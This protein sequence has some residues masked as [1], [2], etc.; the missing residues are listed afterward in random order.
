MKIAKKHS[1]KHLQ[2]HKGIALVVVLFSLLLLSLLIVGLLLRAG[3]ENRSSSQY[4]AN[5]SVR[6]LS[7]M[8]VN[9]VQAQIN[10]ATS[11]SPSMTWASQPGAIR[12]FS[13][14]GSLSLI[15]KLYSS[16]ALT[17]STATTL[18][19][20]IPS[21]TWTSQPA[22]WTD[23]N[24]P[25]TTTQ[26]DG[27]TRTLF[28]V[29]DP[30]NPSDLSSPVNIEGFTLAVPPG[31]ATTTQP[32]PMPVRWLYVLQDGRMVSPAVGENN[33][34]MTINGA[35]P[36]N[37][38]V[39]RIAFWTD[40]ETCKININ[41]A[42]DGTFWDT[43]HFNASDERNRSI[44]Q[45]AQGEF[46]AYPGHPAT[47]TLQK[48]F[49]GL[50]NPGLTTPQLF[51]ISPRYTF[52]GSQSGNK[53]ATSPI[54]KKTER[55]YS[56]VGELLF[57]P[58]RTPNG[59]LTSQQLE[60]ARFFLTAHSSAPEVT[61]FGTPRVAI[62]PIH[63]TNDA[64]HRSAIDKLIAFCSTI[65]GHPF[66]F[67][68]NNP[69]SRTDD[70]SL[71]RNPTL[72]NYLDHFTSTA[73]PGFENSFSSK[74]G[75]PGS[76]QIL[77]EIFDYIRI[78]NLNDPTVTSPYLSDL[79]NF[80]TNGGGIG[81]VTPSYH[82]DW[83]TRGLGRFP[84]LSEVSML[85][86]GMGKGASGTTAA[87]PVDPRQPLPP[88]NQL[89]PKSYL[90][91][92]GK[93]TP[94]TDTTAVQGFLLLNFF[95]PAH[96]FSM[97]RPGF[98][99]IVNGLNYFTL[100]GDSMG[101]PESGAQA[102][103]NLGTTSILYNAFPFEAIFDFRV[104]I[105]HKRLNQGGQGNIPFF[106]NILPISGSTMTLGAAPITVS[107]YS[108]YNKTPANLIQTYTISF[109]TTTTLPI[110][111]VDTSATALR[112]FGSKA[113]TGNYQPNPVEDRVDTVTKA[114]WF[115]RCINSTYDT[116]ISMVPSAGWSDYRLFALSPPATSTPTA[117]IP[118]NAFTLHPDASP[119]QRLAYNT[120]SCIGTQLT[121]ARSGSLAAGLSGVVSPTFSGTNGT[122]PPDW[123]N[124]VGTYPP[125]PY[126]NKADEGTT[127][128]INS[129][130]V[131]YFLDTYANQTT[132]PTFFSANRQLPSPVMFGS[133]PSGAT[134]VPPTPWQTLLF[135]P[136][137]GNHPGETAPADHLLLDLFWMPVAEPY[138]IS[139]PFATM[140]KINLNYQ[141][142]PFTYITRNTAL[143][144]AMAA[145][146]V[147]MLSASSV[148]SGSLLPL[149]RRSLN[150]SDTDG[151]LRQFKEKFAS[152]D[153]FKSA[154]EICNIFLVPDNQSWTSDNAARTASYG[155]DFAG[156]GDNV[157]ERPYANL[158]PRLTT[159][160]NCFKIFYTVQA[161][162]NPPSNQP[163]QWNEN[164]G[165]I[166]GEQ[167]GSTTIERNID[168]T[169]TNI[170]DYASNT[171]A[172]SLET[173]Y[174]WRI[175]ESD[176]FPR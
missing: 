26:P 99:V 103:S 124:G 176:T 73:I 86:I 28:P 43:P 8:V 53:T 112:L 5:T 71:S 147:G 130:G 58:D 40:D 55:L 142:L 19:N 150:L 143:R 48:V 157:R 66:Y 6:Q 65:N 18:D 12:L 168:P 62:W 41:T 25:A 3:T 108:G 123:D 96:G 125:G 91:I 11:Q 70:I 155:S 137:P 47:T 61:L 9:L 56:S 141:I 156:I 170:P 37:P 78:T 129:G 15:Y 135:R 111:L 162:Q 52:G 4:A 171:A 32:A 59:L 169:D 116:I 164:R 76:R 17:T 38:I 36:A 64:A 14:N 30:R 127:L 118:S 79:S 51:S 81:V 145:E 122:F 75:T 16:D 138:A 161:L 148:N 159:K 54:P 23:I 175:V 35:S 85:F 84:V 134:T 90:G 7:D 106:S 74:Y 154:S 27:T 166:L 39:G 68:R 146:Q 83:N 119:T 69:F 24:A 100:N 13:A 151:T 21:P 165:I 117:S 88:N 121:G 104:L 93:G 144:S 2:S 67:T 31:V 120:R 92:D 153:I 94:P 50:S 110:P 109:P 87:V 20:D 139:E 167:R 49:K 63:D 80:A 149:A 113:V 105:A 102:I 1:L 126:I 158:Y 163:D 22:M 136:G 33:S 77:T 101:M 98:L 107:I 29:M 128:N 72:L 160:S 133:L 82:A 57:E 89:P 46:Q 132:S 114:E 174:R 140:G 34:I 115:S 60:T 45:P 131:P 173:F 44:Y 172:A 97:I 95:N 152:R 42:G 10:H